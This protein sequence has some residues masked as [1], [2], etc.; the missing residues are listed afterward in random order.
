MLF[1]VWNGA[2]LMFF[3]SHDFYL[4]IILL[5]FAAIVATAF[6][7]SVTA[8]VTDGL[9]ELSD[10]LDV[11]AE[12]DFSQQVAVRGR[13]EV[14]HIAQSFNGMTLQLRE[15]EQTRR[16]AEQM[17]RDLVAWVSHDL[18]TPLTSIRAMIEALHD[19]VVTNDQTRQRYYRN[20]RQDILALDRLLN[21]LF[22]L[23]Q[24]DAGGLK[25][26]LMGHDLTDLLSDTVE[27]FHV[28]AEQ[29]GITLHGDIDRNLGRVVVDAGKIERVLG[30]LVGNALRYTPDEGNIFVSAEMA[31]ENEVLVKVEDRGKGFSDED[32]LRVFEKFYRG[33]QA[34]TRSAGGA[35]LGLAIA[36][37]LVEAHGGRIWAE[38][39]SEGGAVVSF[40]L[41]L[42]QEIDWE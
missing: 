29:K 11:V 38:N 5:V 27:N 13:D 3:E 34:R 24:L 26:D 14:A 4:A 8:R 42:T 33:E 1:N 21:D 20:M 15:A 41:P 30:N 31:N 19:G 6:G 23:A 22:E 10:T 16:E 2:R 37:G 9:S 12:G 40:C 35:G 39:S 18:R 36:Q 17:R 25:L 7:F 28:L 32:L